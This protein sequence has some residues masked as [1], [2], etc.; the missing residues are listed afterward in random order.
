MTH[1]SLVAVVG[2]VGAG[3][4]SLI[5][6]VLGEMEKLH[7]SVTVKVQLLIHDV[8]AVKLCR[9]YCTAIHCLYMHKKQSFQTQTRDL[10]V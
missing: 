1:G 3:K 4:S 10:F 5:S 7:G 2:S 8:C 9:L 6:A